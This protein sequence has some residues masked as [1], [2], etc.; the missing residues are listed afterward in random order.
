VIFP[1]NL[2]AFYTEKHPEEYLI[3]IWTVEDG[4]P[5]NAIKALHHTRDGFIWIGTPSGLVRFDGL[6]FKIYTRWNLPVLKDDNITCIYEDQNQVLWVGTDGGGLCTLEDG[7]WHRYSAENGLSSDHIRV[8]I[9]DFNGDIWV[10]TDYGLNRINKDGIRIF[11]KKDGL[12]DNTIT[13]LTIDSWNNLWIGTFRGGLAKFN[14]DIFSIFGYQEGLKNLSIRTLTVGS[15]GI[16][17]IGTYEGIYFIKRDEGIVHQVKGTSYT[18]I[19]SIMEKSIG[20]LWIGTMVSGVKKMNPIDL[21]RT[22]ISNNLPDDFIHCTIKDN[23]GNIWLGTDTGGLVQLK[24]RRISNVTEQHGLP[25]GATSAVYQD[26]FESVWI[27]TRNKGLVQIHDNR[28]IRILTTSSGLSSN[29][30]RVISEDPKGMLWIGTDG[31]GINILKNQGVYLKLTAEDGLSSNQINAILQDHRG[32]MWIGTE[33]GLN[34]YADGRFTFYNKA[35][36][37]NNRRINVLL[38]SQSHILYV[39]TDNGI[40]Q[41][42]NNSVVPIKE[43]SVEGFEVISLFEDRDGVLWIGTNGL[44]LFRWYNNHFDRIT[45]ENGL[46]DNF[47]LSIQGDDDH[48]LWMSSHAGV[49]W[50]KRKDLSNFFEKKNSRVHSTWYDESEGMISRQCVGD[51][52]PSVLRTKDDRIIYP[53]I[54]GISIIDPNLLMDYCTIPQIIIESVYCGEDTLELSEEIIPQ[55]A[56][57][58]I[59]FDFTATEFSAPN[60]VSFMYRLD[61]VENRKGFINPGDERK[62]TFHN[63]PFGE[64]TFHL[65]ASNNEGKWNE[66][67]TYFTF[68]VLPPFFLRPEFIAILLGL[69]LIV[70]SLIIYINH[71]RKKQKQENKYKTSSLDSAKIDEI[72][73]KLDELIAREKLFLNP[74]LTLADL[75]SRLKIH[76]NYISRIINENF[77]MSYNDF[78]NKYRI[79]EVKLRL[80]DP[81]YKNK[82]V[83]E[84]MYETGFYSKSVF[85]TAFKK[86]TGMTP[87]EYRKNKS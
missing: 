83:L 22:I 51:G 14:H 25:D 50:V 65:A 46:I 15:K 57:K 37:P 78:I 62:V 33:E 76:Y 20:E 69:T 82:T 45:K 87:S 52:E 18:P 56:G 43:A 17:W 32:R 39:G 47:I 29:K 35:T 12:Y 3:N 54:K 53:T 44:G 85:N 64:H 28:I 21:T 16:L 24:I 67:I 10:G 86:F 80:V 38:E 77:G 48:N 11:T 60:K 34:R 40:F 8:I 59:T 66:Q 63:L 71:N 26:R 31:G 19:N 70:S 42:V 75:A 30:I 68:I 13:A 9:S 55:L 61:G 41:V 84:V 4:L 58:M 23:A 79:E 49:F 27:G 7:R 6:N 36:D 1:S 72:V 81:E 74:D 73:S 5:Q 2:F